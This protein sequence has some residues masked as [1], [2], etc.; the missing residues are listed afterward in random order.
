MRLWMLGQVRTAGEPMGSARRLSFACLG[1][2]LQAAYMGEDSHPGV[3]RLH[4][5]RTFFPGCALK[6]GGI[7]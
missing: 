3:T 4:S 6:I 7:P 5:P 1:A 2:A